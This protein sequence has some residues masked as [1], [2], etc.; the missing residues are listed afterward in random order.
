MY[1]GSLCHSKMPH[2]NTTDVIV[3]PHFLG[4]TAVQ[5]L[6]GSKQEVLE[7]TH[8]LLLLLLH[9]SQ[10]YVTIC[11]QVPGDKSHVHDTAA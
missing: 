7:L 3:E 8:I 11:H 2:L 6:A 5:S 4:L 9:C 1:D 10:T